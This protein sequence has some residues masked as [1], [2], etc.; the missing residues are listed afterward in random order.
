MEA[1]YEEE[2]E[3]IQ[4]ELNSKQ[5][6]LVSKIKLAEDN[7]SSMTRQQTDM[8]EQTRAEVMLNNVSIVIT[9]FHICYCLYTMLP[10][11]KL[12]KYICIRV[13]VH[14]CISPHAH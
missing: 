12:T 7:L 5:T 2:N 10:H 11:F 8:M 1:K 13:W 14:W 6:D 4:R 3:A 9:K